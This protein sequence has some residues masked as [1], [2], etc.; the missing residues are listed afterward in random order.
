MSAENVIL[1]VDDIPEYVETLEALLPDGCRA[2]TAAD[3][4]TAKAVVSRVTP[5]V[6]VIDVRLAENEETNRD[7]LEL[8]RWLRQEKPGVPVIMLSAYQEFE[9]HAESLAIGADY[10][11]TKPIRPD[12]FVVA[13]A[14]LLGRQGT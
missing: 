9:Y 5:T 7:G 8:L 13:L 4:A 11:L 2:E 3:L 14:E 12:E 1:L 10:F 6:A